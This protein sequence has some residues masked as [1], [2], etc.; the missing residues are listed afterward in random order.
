LHIDYAESHLHEQYEVGNLSELITLQSVISPTNDYPAINHSEDIHIMRPDIIVTMAYPLACPRR[1]LLI[2]LI[3]ANKYLNDKSYSNRAWGTITGLS[4]L[5][6]SR[7]ELEFLNVIE[8]RLN[9]PAKIFADFGAI[10]TKGWKA[11]TSSLYL[12]ICEKE[13]MKMSRFSNQRRNSA[14]SI[15]CP[16]R[17]RTPVAACSGYGGLPTP[18]TTLS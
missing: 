11:N 3:L 10:V 4:P 7:L 17:K 12:K 6:I 5:E 18:G 2:S 1:G 16:S 15:Y 14:P 8:H 9:I 13:K